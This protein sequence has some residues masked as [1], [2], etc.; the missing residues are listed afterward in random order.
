MRRV[1]VLLAAVGLIA[2]V[3]IGLTQAGGDKA[4]D[5]GKGFT[6]Y[7]VSADRACSDALALASRPG[8]PR[9]L[10]PTDFD[11]TTCEILPVT[12]RINFKTS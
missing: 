11:K 12:G 9:R 8:P 6:Y 3:V 4:T 1:L 2:V 5:A 7:A 10:N